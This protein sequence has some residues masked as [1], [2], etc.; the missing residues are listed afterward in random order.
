MEKK[1]IYRAT[2]IALVLVLLIAYFV[3]NPSVKTQDDNSGSNLVQEP[4]STEQ[5]AS[6]NH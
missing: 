5:L 6:Q 1:Y 4:A 2:S 3:L